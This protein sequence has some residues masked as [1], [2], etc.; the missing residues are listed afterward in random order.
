MN[1]SA[2]QLEHTVVGVGGFDVRSFTYIDEIQ[3][4]GMS[5]FHISNLSFNQ[6]IHNQSTF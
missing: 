1:M 5:Y 3:Q 4:R 6:S 2:S